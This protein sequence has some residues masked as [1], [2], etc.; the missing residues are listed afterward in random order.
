MY[1]SSGLLFHCL[2]LDAFLLIFIYLFSILL[3]ATGLTRRDK[4]PLPDVLGIGSRQAR[5]AYKA[6]SRCLWCFYF[7]GYGSGRGRR[8]Q[9]KDGIMATGSKEVGRQIKRD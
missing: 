9:Y 7:L 2:L 5:E 8:P 4:T 1:G 6:G 3:Y